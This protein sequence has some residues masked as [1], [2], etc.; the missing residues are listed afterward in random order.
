MPRRK[1][2]NPASPEGRKILSAYR[3]S[4]TPEELYAYAVYRTPGVEVTD[5]TGMY[6]DYP[7]LPPT[8]AEY[9]EMIARMNACMNA[10]CEANLPPEATLDPEVRKAFPT[11]ED[12]NRALRSLMA[13]ARTEEAA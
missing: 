1:N 13:D 10:E 5:M 2:I 8:L 12:V 6:Q 3:R 7:E 9:R 11:D 4:M